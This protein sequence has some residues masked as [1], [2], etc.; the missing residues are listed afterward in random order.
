MPKISPSILMGVTLLMS[1]GVAQ[2][3]FVDQMKSDRVKW[4]QVIRDFNI[5]P[6]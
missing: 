2:A 4:G 5:K 6:E 3:Q 1:M